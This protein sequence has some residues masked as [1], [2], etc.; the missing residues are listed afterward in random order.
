MSFEDAALGQD[1]FF[2]AASFQ[3][4]ADFN[5]SK[6][7]SYSYFAAAQFSG[8]ALF[9]DVDFSAASDFSA[10]SFSGKANF[11]RSRL[12]E[13]Y[14]GDAIFS[15]PAQFG[16]INFDG[17]SSFGGAVFADEAGF[18]LARFTDAAYF[19]GATF[20]DLAL[21]ENYLR[22]GWS[23]DEDDCYYQYRMLDQAGK[24]WG[25]P[26]AIDL[27]AWLS[28]G[29]GVR[30]GYALAWSLLTILA[31]GLVFWRGDGIRRSSKPLP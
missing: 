16:L 4:N 29:Y 17:L 15:G 14:F 5:Y 20:Q 2:N 7:D 27:L 10:S 6:F 13:P 23:E 1:T 22:L 18:G 26:K 30:P 9:S 3:G 24:N 12:V 21:F 31:F 19:S 28:C 25:W 8:D 11:I